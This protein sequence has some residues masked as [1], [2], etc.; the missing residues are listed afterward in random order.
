MLKADFL[1][2]IFIAIFTLPILM[3][4]FTK[5]SREKIQSSLWSLCDGLEFILVLFL[6][7]YLTRGIFFQH[8][9]G[10]F[11]QIYNEIPKEIRILLFGQDILI[12]VI[13][14]PLMV[15]LFRGLI[16][17]ITHPIYS[18]VSGPLAD[19][20]YKLLILVGSGRRGG[21]IGALAQI[22]RAS[23][24]VFVFALLINFY[25]YYFPAPRLTKMMSDSKGY[26]FIYKNAVT[27]A[28]NSNLA[29]KIPVLVNDYFRQNKVSGSTKGR[30]ITYFNGATL[31]EA[32]KSD[33]QIDA[34]ARQVV[35]SEQ[36]SRQK[37]YLIYRWITKHIK[38]D[39]QKAAQL[40]Q[41]PSGLDSGAIVAFNTR[42]GVCFDYASLYVA[43]CR[44]VG[45]KVRLVTGL[46][47]SGTSWGDHAWNQV[48]V[49]EEGRWIN[50]DPTFG[51]VN[52]YFDKP[53]FN[54]D[55]KDSKVQGE[56]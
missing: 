8:D 11:A 47:Y 16:G 55:H 51:T 24:L 3:G 38:Y 27:L 42:K 9:S 31:D 53:D 28:L 30:V 37:G 40:G 45:L 18:A 35:G 15:G 2:L 36:N 17:L 4:A 22:P 54:V 23:V 49:P 12:Y 39:E 33:V 29:Q 50:V 25:A 52:N 14:V 43:M 41:D 19:R 34:T 20:L 6:A 46:G 7:I 26:Q 21:I 10:L 44:A 1:T 5:F 56:W 48:Y 32:V 13:V